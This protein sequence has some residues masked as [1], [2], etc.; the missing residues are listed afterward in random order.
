MK[1]K[2]KSLYTDSKWDEAGK[3]KL[4]KQVCLNTLTINN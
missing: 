3:N 1:A 4:Y 2:I